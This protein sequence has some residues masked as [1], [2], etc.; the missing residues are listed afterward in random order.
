MAGI[1]VLSLRTR[2][3]SSPDST[4]EEDAESAVCVVAE[5]C[6]SYCTTL[7]DA[8]V[9]RTTPGCACQ[10]EDPGAS[11]VT[12]TVTKSTDPFVW[13][14]TAPVLKCTG[15]LSVPRDRIVE[16]KPLGSVANTV[17]PNTT[18]RASASIE[19]RITLRMF[20]FLLLSM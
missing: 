7:P 13:N 12:V 1:E 10:P 17:P 3:G 19:I 18:L 11:M 5:Q 16:W 9:T 6:S 14:L 20:L 15:S 8:T 2:P 4:N